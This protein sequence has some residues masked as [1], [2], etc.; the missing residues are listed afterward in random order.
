[1]LM[2][3]RQRGLLV[4]GF[5][6]EDIGGFTAARGE[7][8]D[9]TLLISPLNGTEHQLVAARL[10]VVLAEEAPA[11]LTVLLSPVVA[12]RGATDRLLVPDVAVVRTSAL[13]GGPLWVAPDDVWLAAEIAS[14][15]SR[16]V[17]LHLKRALYADWGVE[18]Y[19][20]LDPDS[21]EVH[22]FGPHPIE[23]SWLAEVDLDVWPDA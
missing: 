12:R 5:R 4:D 7:V 6:L 13:T 17:D 14:P 18:A 9:G 23:G 3:L 21:R 15:P 8:V 2:D 11:E 20:V 22:R 19:W 1:M 16:A 10:A